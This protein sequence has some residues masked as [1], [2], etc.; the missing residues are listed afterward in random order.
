MFYKADNS[1]HYIQ[2]P[3]VQTPNAL[4]ITD[5]HL[6][7]PT[8]HKLIVYEVTYSVCCSLSQYQ[9]GI[10]PRQYQA[11]N[12]ETARASLAYFDLVFDDM[13]MR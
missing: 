13:I 12:I 10:K 8:T 5:Q 4:V 3:W 9:G 7:T 2:K 11:S 6:S 1:L